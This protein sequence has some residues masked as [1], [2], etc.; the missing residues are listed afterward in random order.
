MD[1]SSSRTPPRERFPQLR[2]CPRRDAARRC[3]MGLVV[4]IVL[5]GPRWQQASGRP[6]FNVPD[7]RFVPD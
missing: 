6:G 3:R 7:F 2:E 4:W 1:F 5:M